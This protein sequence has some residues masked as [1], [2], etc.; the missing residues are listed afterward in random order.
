MRVQISLFCFFVVHVGAVS[1]RQLSSSKMC[2]ASVRDSEKMG[3]LIEYKCH[4]H[5]I[6]D[7]HFHKQSLIYHPDKKT[8]LSSNEAFVCLE[9]ARQRLKNKKCKST[10]SKTNSEKYQDFFPWIHSNIIFMIL[11]Y[12]GVSILLLNFQLFSKLLE[13]ASCMRR[14]KIL[15]PYDLSHIAHG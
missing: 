4:N 3:F 11:F 7:K 6:I 10:N 12:T 5:K 8:S 2:D 1:I 9:Q 15:N 13:I 14:G